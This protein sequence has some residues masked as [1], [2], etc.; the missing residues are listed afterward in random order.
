MG[1][2][3]GKKETVQ[4]PDKNLCKLNSRF[5]VS[6]RFLMYVSIRYRNGAT[7]TTSGKK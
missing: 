7:T 3:E 4:G 6:D 5:M 1:Q 2:K